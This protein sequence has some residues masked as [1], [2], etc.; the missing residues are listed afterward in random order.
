[1]KRKVRVYARKD[2]ALGIF[3]LLLSNKEVSSSSAIMVAWQRDGGVH[4]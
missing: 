1:M 2:N 4:T 3:F